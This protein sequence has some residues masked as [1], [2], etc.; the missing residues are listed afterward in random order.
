MTS[1]WSTLSL[2]G[3]K[4]MTKCGLLTDQRNSPNRSQY[5]MLFTTRSAAVED[6]SINHFDTWAYWSVLG[7][8]SSWWRHEMETFSALLAFCAGHSP[9][10]GELPAQRLVTRSFGVFFDRRLNQQFSKRW[11]RWWFEAPSRWLWRQCNVYQRDFNTLSYPLL[12]IRNS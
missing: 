12:A 8:R 1:S 9:V 3:I 4:G 10:I 2:Y 6:N 11:R 7:L 5:F